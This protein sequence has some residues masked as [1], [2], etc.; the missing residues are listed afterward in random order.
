MW[1]WPRL[2]LGMGRKVVGE[3]QLLDAPANS[4][5]LNKRKFLYKPAAKIFFIENISIHNYYIN[6]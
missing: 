6:T 3:S 1:G 4:G 5:D 2:Q